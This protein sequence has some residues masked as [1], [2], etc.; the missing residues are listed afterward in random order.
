MELH[1]AAQQLLDA[2]EETQRIRISISQ[3]NY[4]TNVLQTSFSQELEALKTKDAEY[5]Q[6]LADVH[7]ELIDITSS[8]SSD[9]NAPSPGKLGYSSV[10]AGDTVKKGDVINFNT[11]GSI[12]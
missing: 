9:V 6:R 4:E 8:A 1:D 3:I 2:K 10:I 12:T 5:S 7:Q 11:T